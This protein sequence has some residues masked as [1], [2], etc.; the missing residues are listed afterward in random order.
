MTRLSVA[1]ISFY[2]KYLS[3]RKGFRCAHAA[4]Y[5]G[6]SC[7]EAV[8]LIILQKGLIGGWAD[9]KQR[10]MDCKRVS[11]EAEKERD[12]RKDRRKKD[13]SPPWWSDCASCVPC[14][15]IERGQIAVTFRVIAI[16]S[17]N[18]K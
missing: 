17:R 2:Q 11:V 1:F 4:Y 3:P 12:K 18:V 8:K 6:N 7:S 9:I 15:P 14:G 16:R 5:S 13:E 10:F